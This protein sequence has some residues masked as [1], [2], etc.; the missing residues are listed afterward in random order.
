MDIQKKRNLAKAQENVQKKK[1]L[2]AEQLR[3]ETEAS[4]KGFV[5][6]LSDVLGR[7]IKVDGI[8]DVDLLVS[9]VEEYGQRVAEFVAE[10]ARC[11]AAI[12]NLDEL[13][14]PE[15]IELKSVTDEKL[16]S[17]LRELG[18]QSE[19][20][21][22]LQNL[23]QAVVLLAAALQKDQSAGQKAEDYTPVRIVLGRDDKLKFLE[24]WP[25]PSFNTGGQSG[26]LTDAQLR[27]SPVP[28]TAT[29]DTT[30]LATSAKQDTLIGYVD[31]LETLVT[32][33]NTKLDSLNTAVGTIISKATDAYSVVAISNDGTYKYFWF[34]DATSNYYIMRKTLATSIFT[35]T[36][37]TGGYSAVYQ[38]AILGP[39]GSPTF[40][41]YGTTF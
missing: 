24:N 3:S 30:G 21:S 40:A 39:S 37:G 28:V 23:D 1:T 34:E 11:T 25:M 10:I 31:G 7:G 17:T 22:K 18:D 41:S 13:T 20:I 2:E 9:R 38:S 27:A 14:L 8:S 4:L 35:Y 15:S 29:I 5:D 33:T 16:I 19:L 26:G 12:P 6:G 32:S 36:K